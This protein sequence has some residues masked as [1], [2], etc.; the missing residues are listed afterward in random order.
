V[1]AKILVKL[2]T[3][4]PVSTKPSISTPFICT[5]SFGL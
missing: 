2:V 1:D 4:V 5:F 3:S